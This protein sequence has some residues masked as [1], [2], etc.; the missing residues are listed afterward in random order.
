MIYKNKTNIPKK[1]NNWATKFV[2]CSIQLFFNLLPSKV[3][4]KTTINT[5]PIIPTTKKINDGIDKKFCNIKEKL[6]FFLLI[7]KEVTINKKPIGIVMRI[8]IKK[9]QIF[10]FFNITINFQIT[11]DRPANKHN[12]DPSKNNLL[13]NLIEIKIIDPAKHNT[14]KASNKA[15]PIVKSFGTT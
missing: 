2:I 10:F 6:M 3:K 4:P 14:G 9:N 5:I 1:I 7:I 11:F 12:K 13:E 8:W 15:K